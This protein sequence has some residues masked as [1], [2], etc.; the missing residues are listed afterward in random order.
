MRIIY[1]TNSDGGCACIFPF[2]TLLLRALHH[3]TV[4]DC[5]PG[6]LWK[7]SMCASHPLAGPINPAHLQGSSADPEELLGHFDWRGVCHAGGA[8][9]AWQWVAGGV[10]GVMM[11]MNQAMGVIAAGCPKGNGWLAGGE[12][13]PCPS[14]CV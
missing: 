9:P 11:S 5:A 10:E 8:L 2:R 7:G 14:A 3:L 1:I 12:V 4:V 13:E 6:V